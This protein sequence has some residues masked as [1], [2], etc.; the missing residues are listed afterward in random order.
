MNGGVPEMQVRVEGWG[1]V[2]VAVLEAARLDLATAAG[3]RRR[4]EAILADQPRVALDLSGVAF[5]DSTG[6]GALLSSLHRA[7][8]L[9]GD[10]RLFGATRPVAALFEM[11]RLERVGEVFPARDEALRAFR[12]DQAFP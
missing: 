8:E 3:F 7:R 10:I 9:G 1:G 11:V 12:S 5:M 6:L 4:M 2:T